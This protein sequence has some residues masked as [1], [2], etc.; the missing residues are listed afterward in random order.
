MSVH[1]CLPKIAQLILGCVLKSWAKCILPFQYCLNAEQATW[2]LWHPEVVKAF[3]RHLKMSKH[4]FSPL[5]LCTCVRQRPWHGGGLLSHQLWQSSTAPWRCA[6]KGS[7]AKGRWTLKILQ[8]FS[9][10]DRFSMTGDKVGPYTDL[11]C[12][13]ILLRLWKGWWWY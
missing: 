5:I 13:K 8:R 10:Q 6:G 12:D 11:T 9:S 4:L 3:R 2:T 1:V 7:R